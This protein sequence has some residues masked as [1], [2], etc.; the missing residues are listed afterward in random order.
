MGESI[1]R[2]LSLNCKEN[3]VWK[4]DLFTRMSVCVLKPFVSISKGL[5]ECEHTSGILF[6]GVN[7]YTRD[8]LLNSRIFIY[9][10]TKE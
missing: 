8:L 5:G 9:P 1:Q 10:T 4:R 7:S 6:R 3:S 2:Q